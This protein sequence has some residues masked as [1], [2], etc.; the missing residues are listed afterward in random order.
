MKDQRVGLRRTDHRRCGEI[1]K[2]E[3]QHDAGDSAHNLV[4]SL[5]ADQCTGS[6]MR[7]GGRS[8][9]DDLRGSEFAL[10]VRGEP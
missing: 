8:L 6:Q 7:P 9:D 2:S 5:Q 3:I 10:R 4:T 1:V